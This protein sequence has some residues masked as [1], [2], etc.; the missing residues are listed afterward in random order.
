MQELL[1]ASD[2]MINDFS[3]SMWDFMLTGRPSFLFAV[4]LDHYVATTEVYTPVSEWP[5]PKATSNDELE[6]N[7]L[8]FSEENY[9][10]SC[11]RHYRDLGGS[12]TGEATK[13]ICQRIYEQCYS[14]G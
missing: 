3:S 10:A 13:L 14:K 8:N 4:D 5:F 6:Q 11:D 12:E 2:A 1:C 9:A 7:I